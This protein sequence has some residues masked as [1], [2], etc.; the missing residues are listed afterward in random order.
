MIKVY[1]KKNKK[2]QQQKTLAKNYSLNKS[3]V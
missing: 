1:K 2:Q 3:F